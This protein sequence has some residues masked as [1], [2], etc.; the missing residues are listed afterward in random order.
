MIA[1]SEASAERFE[2]TTSKRVTRRDLLRLGAS[3]AATSALGANGI[4][5]LAQ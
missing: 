1:E 4:P 2:G 3:W 5:A